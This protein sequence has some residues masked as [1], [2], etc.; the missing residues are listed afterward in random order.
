MK[1]TLLLSVAMLVAGSAISQEATRHHDGFYFDKMSANGKYLATQALGSVFIYDGANDEYY[2]YYA[3]EDAV[4]EYYATGLG[5]CI[6]ND[7]VLVGGFNDATCAYW[8]DGEWYPLSVKPE[9]QALNL[10]N[11]IT[12]DG[13][14]I[15]GSVGNMGMD[16]YSSQM[17]KPVYWDRNEEGQ[18]Y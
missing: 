12:P 13:S 14:R 11:G 5:N 9:N 17:I 3:S 10:A 2:E 6:S 7:G 4:S 16:M 8:Q 18:S 15:V 1:K